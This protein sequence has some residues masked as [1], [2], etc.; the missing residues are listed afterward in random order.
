MNEKQL[1]GLTMSEFAV[2]ISSEIFTWKYQLEDS[3]FFFI[4]IVL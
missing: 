2:R 4:V 1:I 3:I